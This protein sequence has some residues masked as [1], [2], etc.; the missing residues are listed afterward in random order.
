MK[1]AKTEPHARS[2]EGRQTR[3]LEAIAANT[4]RIADV[5]ESLAK[6]VIMVISGE[7]PDHEAE[8]ILA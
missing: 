3:A 5:Q 8:E 7:Q 1:K 4:A 2:H 6:R